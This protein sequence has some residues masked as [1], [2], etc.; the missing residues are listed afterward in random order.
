VESSL[1]APLRSSPT[2]R[3]SPAFWWRNWFSS[4][5]AAPQIRPHRGLQEQQMKISTRR[6]TAAG[7]CSQYPLVHSKLNW[8]WTE[9]LTTHTITVARHKLKLLRC[10]VPPFSPVNVYGNVCCCLVTI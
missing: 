7:R 4:A 3:T 8:N 6:R 9:P 5:F 1:G 2:S 10:T